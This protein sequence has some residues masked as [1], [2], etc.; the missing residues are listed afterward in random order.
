MEGNTAV[1][2]NGLLFLVQLPVSVHT[3][4]YAHTGTHTDTHK[5]TGAQAP[6]T[7]SV[8]VSTHTRSN[9]HANA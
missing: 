6:C 3:Q 9:N 1:S 8:H 2:N 5:P 4:A 7:R